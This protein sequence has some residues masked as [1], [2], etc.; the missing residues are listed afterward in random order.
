MLRSCTKSAVLLLLLWNEL[1]TPFRHRSTQTAT[2][3]F[4]CCSSN[5]GGTSS[6]FTEWYYKTKPQDFIVIEDRA[7]ERR[8]VK[9][10]SVAETIVSEV[11]AVAL[12]TFSV[13]YLVEVLSSSQFAE[14]D[15][16]ASA[17]LTS[18]IDKGAE[19]L[20]L[21]IN[22]GLSKEN[23]TRFHRT[24]A[25]VYPRLDSKT[26]VQWNDGSPEA[27]ANAALLPTI[28]RIYPKVTYL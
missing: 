3:R 7:L 16:L 4:V 23:R 8:E 18:T 21:E 5:K 24:I 28:I 20:V 13:D 26:E 6:S 14:L 22:P 27:I 17:A 2:N 11:P 25:H 1:V 15:G 9:S 12:E 19:S 10:P